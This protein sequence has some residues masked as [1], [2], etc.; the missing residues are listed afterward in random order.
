[1]TWLSGRNEWRGSQRMRKEF[2]VLGALCGRTHGKTHDREE[3][4]AG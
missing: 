1:V 2:G 3:E 4:R